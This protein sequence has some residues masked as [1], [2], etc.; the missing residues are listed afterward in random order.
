[1]RGRNWSLTIRDSNF[2]FVFQDLV[3]NKKI[4]TFRIELRLKSWSFRDWDGISE[5]EPLVIYGSKFSIFNRKFQCLKPRPF[6]SGVRTG[7]GRLGPKIPARPG[8]FKHLKVI[9][10]NVLDLI[11]I[12]KR[13]FIDLHKPP[14]LRFGDLRRKFLHWVF[15]VFKWHLDSGSKGS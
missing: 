15:E 6:G 8:D 2:E 10:W 11:E 12:L 4:K 13:C 7:P 14:I 1:M 5:W 9:L 3:R